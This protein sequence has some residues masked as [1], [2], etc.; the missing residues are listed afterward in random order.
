M[1][2]VSD[3]YILPNQMFWVTIDDLAISFNVIDFVEHVEY[4][5]GRGNFIGSF[6]VTK[7]SK[8]MVISI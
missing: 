4:D 7:S 1:F 6:Y 5:I 8:Y 3:A 2:W